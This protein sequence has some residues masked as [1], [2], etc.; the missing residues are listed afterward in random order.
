[1]V[2]P[3]A[4]GVLPTGTVTFLLTDIEASTRLWEEHPVEMRA[5]VARHDQIVAAAVEDNA[6]KLVKA[7][8]EGDS[9]F[10][11]F[12]RATEAV[13]TALELQRTMTAEPWP[14]GV[15]LRVR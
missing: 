8:G 2:E 4:G 7:K 10:A 13:A 9:A 1:M 12:A 14:S 15:D 11:V 6:G 3:R 5:A